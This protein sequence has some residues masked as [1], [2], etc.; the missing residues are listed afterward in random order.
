MR[1]SKA[2]E[3]FGRADPL[4]FQRRGIELLYEQQMLVSDIRQPT[5]GLTPVFRV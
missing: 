2:A 5:L 4:K 1:T 3:V